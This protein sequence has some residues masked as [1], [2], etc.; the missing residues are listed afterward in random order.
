[1]CAHRTVKRQE[2]KELIIPLISRNRWRLPDKT[3]E[4][5][6]APVKP[7]DLTLQA[8]QEIIQETQRAAEGWDKRGDGVASNI[9]IPLFMQNRVPSGFETNDKVD[10]SLRADQV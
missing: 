7:D 9:E 10:V 1:M 3:T 2:K 6:A 8:A 5:D 4:E